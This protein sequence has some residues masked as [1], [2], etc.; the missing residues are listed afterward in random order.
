[1]SAHTRIVIAGGGMVG[2]SLALLLDERLP[3]PARITL[4]EG[5]ALPPAEAGGAAYHPSFDARSTA[6]SY[7]TAA[8]YR[9]LGLW[10][11]LE[12]GTAPIQ[13]I[14][15]SRRGRPGSTRLLAREQGW[16]AL[17][18]VVENPCLGRSLLKAVRGRPRIE[19]YCP[20]R[21]TGAEARGSGMAV[22]IDDDAVDCDLLV[23]ADGAGSTLREQLRFHT[24]RKPYRE[25][26][27]VAN[28]AMELRHEGC[29]FERFTATGPLALLPLP[30]TQEAPSRMA[31]VWTLPPESAAELEQGDDERFAQALQESFGHRLGR[32]ERVG[33]ISRYPLA[34]TEAVEQVRRGCVVIGNAAHALHPVAGQGFNLALRDV[35]A[36]ARALAQAAAKGVPVGDT[37]VLSAYAAARQRDQE[38]TIAASDG[39]P[40]LFMHSDPILGLGR[41]LAL[42][43]LDIFPRLRREFVRQAAGM[44]ALEVGHG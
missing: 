9:D 23:I 21:V 18:W 5:I 38:Q 25:E 14:H 39:L 28:L 35:S 20:A 4:V 3:Q 26:A 2:L 13:S 12:V 11:E 36:L 42:A 44:A 15:V 34:L 32:V 22:T 33:R 41:D 31:L 6:L 24:R 27:V 30:P 43:G 1:M 29:A 40:A 16:D 37:S 7:S 8:I 10:A 17:G 19:L